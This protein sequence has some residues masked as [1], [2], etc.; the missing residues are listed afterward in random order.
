MSLLRLKPDIQQTLLKL[1]DP[2]Q[3]PIITVNS[4]GD[5]ARGNVEKPEGEV[6]ALLKK[7]E[8]EYQSLKTIRPMRSPKNHI[9][10]VLLAMKWQDAI[11]TNKYK[12]QSGLARALGL[13]PC[14]V[15]RIMSL[16]ELSPEVKDIVAGLGEYLPV[17]FLT[18]TKLREL[19]NL[20]SKDQLREVKAILQ[21]ASIFPISPFQP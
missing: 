21:E 15:R 3:G 5:I 17:G 18:E 19:V 9:N 7:K 12:S 6:E 8:I 20:S 13:D 11:A 14:R 2:L 10:P 1:G 4:L 16:L